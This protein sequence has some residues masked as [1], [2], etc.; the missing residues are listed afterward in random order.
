M[1]FSDVMA[2]GAGLAAAWIIVLLLVLLI[3]IL[4]A[5]QTQQMHKYGNVDIVRNLGNAIAGLGIVVCAVGIV[6]M[7][8]LVGVVRD[9]RNIGVDPS[10]IYVSRGN[11]YL[12]W[13]NPVT[14]PDLWKN[15]KPPTDPSQTINSLAPVDGVNSCFQGFSTQNDPAAFDKYRQLIAA[16]QSGQDASTPNLLLYQAYQEVPTFGPQTT[17]AA[18]ITAHEDSMENQQMLSLAYYRFIWCHKTF[19]Q[20]IY[21]GIGNTKQAGTL[22]EEQLPFLIPDT[23]NRLNQQ[24]KN[25]CDPTNINIPDTVYCLDGSWPANP[26]CAASSINPCFAALSDSIAAQCLLYDDLA[27]KTQHPTARGALGSFD[28]IGAPWGY[29]L[30]SPSA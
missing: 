23:L 24:S 28:V 12:N 25:G 14:T 17:A 8:L 11:L 6:W 7:V 13:Y 16:Y 9:A 29:R 10:T 18:V 5:M 2:H 4:Y 30:L 3:I 20:T 1:G 19:M 26:T 22:T 15:G 21:N 27:Y